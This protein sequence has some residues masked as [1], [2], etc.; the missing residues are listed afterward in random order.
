MKGVTIMPKKTNASTTEI[1]EY[2]IYVIAD[3]KQKQCYIGNTPVKRSASEYWDH[4]AGRRRATKELFTQGKITNNDPKMYYLTTVETTK[5]KANSY[6]IPYI[7]FFLD[8]GFS[9]LNSTDM[10][11]YTNDLLKENQEL[12]DYIKDYPIEKLCAEERDLTPN[13]TEKQKKKKEKS[14]NKMT[15]NV[16]ENDYAILK[17]RAEKH[18]MNI[19]KYV[20]QIVMYEGNLVEI[21]FDSLNESIEELQEIKTTLQQIL[22][23][24]YKTGTYYSE[25]LVILQKIVDEVITHE[26]TMIRAIK[27]ETNN[28]NQLLK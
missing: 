20:R 22:Y 21:N 25:D 24:I 13:Y 4:Y 28:L 5:Q 2:M 3:L 1:K 12:Y 15:I 16:T 14:P 23:T 11:A 8:K 7:K 18:N 10:I 9:S 26:K 19:T 27:Q 6:I 17:K